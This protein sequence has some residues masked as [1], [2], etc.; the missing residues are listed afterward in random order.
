M[1]R[2]ADTHGDW[3]LHSPS[4]EYGGEQLYMPPCLVDELK[5][6]RRLRKAE[7]DAADRAEL[8]ERERARD[9]QAASEKA[10]AEVP[11]QPKPAN[12]GA[13]RAHPHEVLT[14]QVLLDSDLVAE[15]VRKLRQGLYGGEDH[16]G[17]EVKALSVALERGP[18][19]SV[20]RR[21][22][23][24]SALEQLAIELPAFRAVIE[25]I[26]NAHAVSEATSALPSIAPMLLVG[27]PGVGKSYF[28]RRLAETLACASRWLAMDQPTAGSD[29]RGSD[30]HWSTARHGALFELL[31]LG[32]TANPLIVLDEI[33]KAARRQTSQEIDPLA[34]LYSALEPETAQRIAD[35]SLD[36][37]LDASQVVYI[38]TANGLR[39]LDA[40]LLSRFEVVQVRIPSPEERRESARRIVESAMEGLGVR[41]EMRVRPG[42][43]VLLADYTPRVIR[44][45]IEKAVGAAMVAGSCQLGIDELEV[46]LGLA[47]RLPALPRWH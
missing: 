45:A 9:A 8:E 2:P 30:K 26:A 36:V 21:P 42:V 37:E 29:L 15:R 7:Q 3:V 28:C 41:N 24:R 31:A 43:I 23:W 34:Q 5:S 10:L 1:S 27:P 4:G 6:E 16:T 47:E 33:D 39:T 38:A 40:A 12:I 13:H 22:E 32:E 17:R 46:A 18:A 14:H 20:V 35:V 11:K 25:V 19:R 44:R